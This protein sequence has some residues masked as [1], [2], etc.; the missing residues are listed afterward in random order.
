MGTKEVQDISIFFGGG[1]G[2]TLPANPEQMFIVL[3]YTVEG[4]LYMMNWE[5]YRR[6][7]L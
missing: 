2:A 5:G 4:L 7:Y 6:K 1:A 3:Y